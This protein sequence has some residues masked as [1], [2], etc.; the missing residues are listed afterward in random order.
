MHVF[1]IFFVEKHV[2]VF[3]SRNAFLNFSVKNSFLG[4]RGKCV[5]VVLSVFMYGKMILCF[6]NL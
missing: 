6:S 5:F 4:F 3:L 1:A 2:F